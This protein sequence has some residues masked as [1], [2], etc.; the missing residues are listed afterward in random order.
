MKKIVLITL[1]AFYSCAPDG[2]YFKDALCIENINTIDAKSG[3]NTE[4]T[5][6]VQDNKIVRV[7]KTSDLTLS[8]KNKI[9]D[10]AGKY[11]IPGLWDAHIHFAFIEEMAPS[12]FDLFLG[13]GVTSVRD[14]GG[15]IEF[16]KAWKDKADS[17]PK[18]A[19]RVKIA[20]PLIDGTPHVYDGSSPTFPPLGVPVADEN[21]TIAMVEKL[22][23]IGVDLLKA[24]EML[25]PEKFK[26]I[27]KM[28]RQKGLKVTGH[29]PLSM[30]VISVSNAGLNSIEHFRNLETS[31]VANWEELLAERREIL[32]NKDQKTGGALR[33]S[34]HN[35]QRY[36]AIKR[37]D[38]TTLYKVL[39][40]LKE[41]DTWQIPTLM[42]NH[43][44]AYGGFQDA[45]YREKFKALPQEIQEEWDMLI[46]KIAEMPVSENTLNFERWAM[47]MVGKM[48]KMG[49]PFMAGTDAPIRFQVPGNSLHGELKLYVEA[50]MSPL[51]ALKTATLLPAT[52][53][54]LQDELGLIEEKMI[55]DLVILDANPLEDI[56]NTQKI[57]AVIKDGHLM[58][59]NHLDQLLK[60]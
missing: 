36:D 30:D 32:K 52:Y 48:H 10:G 4:M 21:A 31:V 41:N 28:A 5:V 8:S 53:F 9:I 27:T 19:P 46:D 43:L 38:S 3:L 37:T 1:M 50:G 6:V 22:D 34:L 15:R 51:E 14:T 55:A 39:N 20:G 44:S 54:N 24:Y 17:D 35:L 56:E 16:V 59:R 12:M 25:T 40:V 60:K 2:E 45:E 42:L 49:I 58:N 23:S 13:Y 29:V 18:N 7:A 57:N 33:S 47:K 11:L 26:T